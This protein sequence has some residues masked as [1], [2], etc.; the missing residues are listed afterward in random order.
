MNNEVIIRL[1][2]YHIKALIIFLYGFMILKMVYLF[3]VNQMY[4]KWF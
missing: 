1:M 3:Q 4:F 2:I